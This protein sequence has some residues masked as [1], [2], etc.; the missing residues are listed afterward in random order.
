MH[1]LQVCTSIAVSLVPETLDSTPV[2][3]CNLG[4][5]KYYY[6]LSHYLSTDFVRC[7][8]YDIWPYSSLIGTALISCEQ[9]IT[10]VVEKAVLKSNIFTLQI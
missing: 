3:Q 5:A 10:I 4:I 8:L 7:T 9:H 1:Y 6:N 2:K